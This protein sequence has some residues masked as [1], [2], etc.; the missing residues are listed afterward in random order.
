MSKHNRVR[1]L[2]GPRLQEQNKCKDWVNGTFGNKLNWTSGDSKFVS[3]HSVLPS[4]ITLA[5]LSITIQLKSPHTVWLI[6]TETT[7]TIFEQERK[8]HI[9]LKKL[10]ILSG[11]K[12]KT[13][14]YLTPFP[15]KM[16]GCKTLCAMC[17]NEC[18]LVQANRSN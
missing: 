1:Q 8:T 13:I 9:S 14:S 3:V 15:E 4:F 17:S 11:K 7:E 10:P 5:F 2:E 6:V 18:G 16:F 12:N